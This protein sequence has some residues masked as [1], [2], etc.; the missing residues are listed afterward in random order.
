MLSRRIAYP[1]K[2]PS[3]ECAWYVF[4]TAEEASMSGVQEQRGREEGQRGSEGPDHTEPDKNKMQSATLSS[5]LAVFTRKKFFKG[6]G[7]W[8]GTVWY[9][10]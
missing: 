6:R 4:C 7:E 5:T 8:N 1:N 2:I 9:L 10:L 3:Q